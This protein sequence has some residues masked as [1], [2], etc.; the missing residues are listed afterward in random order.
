MRLDIYRYLILTEPHKPCKPKRAIWEMSDSLRSQTHSVI[1]WATF[2][3]QTNL[4]FCP[5][6]PSPISTS[7]KNGSNT[8]PT[9]SPSIRYT[10]SPSRYSITSTIRM[11]MGWCECAQILGV[12]SSVKNMFAI[13]S[14]WLLASW[15]NEKSRK[16]GVEKQKLKTAKK[17]LTRPPFFLAASMLG[18]FPLL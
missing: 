16:R 5:N 17:K 7:F 9:P 12:E 13:L 4:A 8:S 2:I 15:N 11:R 3:S 14:D 6:S 1:P 18:Y 10:F